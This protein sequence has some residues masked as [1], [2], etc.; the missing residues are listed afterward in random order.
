M[1]IKQVHQKSVIFVAIGISKIRVLTF[2]QMSVVDV[3][4]Q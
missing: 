1:F 2:K 3:I 4:D